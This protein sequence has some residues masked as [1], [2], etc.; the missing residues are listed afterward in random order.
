MWISACPRR[1]KSD[2]PLE[3]FF[4]ESLASNAPCVLVVPL[5]YTVTRRR[6][7][8]RML[9]GYLLWRA[10][11]A[12]SAATVAALGLLTLAAAHAGV[13]PPALAAAA[14]LGYRT[15]P[16]NPSALAVR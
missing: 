4:V 7:H 8:A 14:W 6:P 9:V 12:L 2:G 16:E 13:V 5:V 11:T 3:S 15:A 10:A 1:L